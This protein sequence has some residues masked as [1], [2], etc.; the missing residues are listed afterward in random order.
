MEMTLN[1]NL[2]VVTGQGNAYGKHTIQV[3]GFDGA[4][5][6][7]YQGKITQSG[8]T[9]KAISHGTGDLAGL[10]QKVNIVQTGETTYETY[11]YVRAR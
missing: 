6:G 3:D 10:I 4:W 9:G 5:E 2:N 1:L 7:T 8:Y 11:G